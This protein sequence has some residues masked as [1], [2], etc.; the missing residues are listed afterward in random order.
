MTPPDDYSA[1]DLE[2]A[3]VLYEQGDK[4]QILFWLDWC[5]A[6]D[7]QVPPWLKEA[8]C[9]AC[10]ARRA[11]RIKSWD[12]VFDPPVPKSTRLAINRQK[13][14]IA[15]PLFE[16]IYDLHAADPAN[17]PIGEKLFEEVG[18]DF[19]FGKTVASELYYEMD[20]KLQELVANTDYF[21][22]REEIIRF[23]KAYAE[24]LKQSAI[25]TSE[26]NKK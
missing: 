4:G 20:R 19:G 18:K 26:Q 1:R 14:K 13:L 5:L 24:S 16:R 25:D 8:F 22:D 17:W 7:V 6:S 2:Q 9:E 23:H 12:D 11:Y 21:K 10:N 3:R 15:W